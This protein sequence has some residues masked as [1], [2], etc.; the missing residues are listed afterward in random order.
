MIQELTQC[1]QFDGFIHGLQ[2]AARELPEAPVPFRSG[3]VG[4]ELLTPYS[5]KKLPNQI[6]VAELATHLPLSQS[7]TKGRIGQDELTPASGVRSAPLR[8]NQYHG[9]GA[10]QRNRINIGHPT[11]ATNEDL[12]GPATGPMDLK[13]SGANDSSGIM[14]KGRF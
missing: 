9:E 13:L 3:L 7:L 4:K 6:P 8:G 1:C 14:L 12:Q 10:P 5:S 2:V 11:A